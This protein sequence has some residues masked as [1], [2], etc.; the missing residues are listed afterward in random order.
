MKDLLDSSSRLRESCGHY[1]ALG[2]SICSDLRP[3]ASPPPPSPAPPRGPSLSPMESVVVENTE[4]ERSVPLA[5]LDPSDPQKS[6]GSMDIPRGRR[7]PL[8]ARSPSPG[9]KVEGRKRGKEAETNPR[10]SKP[11]LKIS[12]Q[13]TRLQRTGQQRCSTDALARSLG[14]SSVRYL[15]LA[16]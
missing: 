12:G 14:C 15:H 3:T 2:D 7:R 13:V 8:P 5:Q 6:R 9:R 1:W 10:T 4:D 11:Y 16:S